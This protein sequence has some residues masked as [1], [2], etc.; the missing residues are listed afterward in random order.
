MLPPQASHRAT[1][2]MAVYICV[3]VLQSVMVVC[4]SGIGLII[5]TRLVSTSS[6]S[7]FLLFLSDFPA[8]PHV[9]HP[10]RLASSGLDGTFSDSGRVAFIFPWTGWM[11][12]S[13]PTRLAGWLVDCVSHGSP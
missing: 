13:E 2:G 4:C 12:Y 7:V 8:T 5:P 3:F 6:V 9:F 1:V 11:P 10:G